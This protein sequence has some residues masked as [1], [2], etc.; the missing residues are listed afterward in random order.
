M[1]PPTLDDCLRLSRTPR[2]AMMLRERFGPDARAS[3]P[4]FAGDPLSEVVVAGP[5]GTHGTS[6]LLTFEEFMDEYGGRY[7]EEDGA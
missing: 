6:D 2:V 7:D 3:E 5:G 4:Y 1:S